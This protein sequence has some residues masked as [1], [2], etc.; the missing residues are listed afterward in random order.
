[1]AAMMQPFIFMAQGS[2]HGDGATI[3]RPASDWLRV[4]FDNKGGS[5]V[6]NGVEF[7]SKKVNCNA[8]KMTLAKLVNT[9][10][11]AVKIAYQ[12]S[13]ETPTMYVLV[14]ASATIEGSCEVKEGNLGKLVF[15]LPETTDAKQNEK[16]NQYILSHIT[17]S[18]VQ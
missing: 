14:P 13:P 5:N 3:A 18:Q 8:E 6:K 9:N 2:S 17:I 11:Y 10:A 4:K 15:K 16:N 12:I 7:Y 1:M